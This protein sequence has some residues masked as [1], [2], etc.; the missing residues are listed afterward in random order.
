MRSITIILVN[1]EIE[2][3]LGHDRDLLG[4]EAGVEQ[5]HIQAHQGCTGDDLDGPDVIASQQPDPPTGRHLEVAQGVADPFGAVE[6]VGIPDRATLFVDHRNGSGAAFG[7]LPQLTAQAVS[8]AQ[9]AVEL[10]NLPVR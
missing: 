4:A 7:G 10:G 1:R 2:R 8:P 3:L 9:Q 5:H 6:Q